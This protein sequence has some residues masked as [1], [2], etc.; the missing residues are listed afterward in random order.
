M[1]ANMQQMASGQMMAQHQVPQRMS[2]QELSAAVTT[3][4]MTQ[5]PIM[6]GWQSGVQVT[7]RMGKIVTL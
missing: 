4:L 7:D 1:A 6:S 3:M 2:S 5:P